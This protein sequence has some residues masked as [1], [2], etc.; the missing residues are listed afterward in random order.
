MPKQNPTWWQRLRTGDIFNLRELI[1][2]IADFRNAT[3]GPETDFDRFM[4]HKLPTFDVSP[5]ENLVKPHDI[6]ATHMLEKHARANWNG[7]DQRLQLFS[8]LYMMTLRNMGIP[9]YCHTALRT[10]EEQKRLY[11][12]G[13][14]QN[15]GPDAPHIRG[16]AVDIVHGKFHWDPTET[17][18][19][20]LGKIGRELNRLL[21]PGPP[22]IWGGDWNNNG[23]PVGEDPKERFWDPAHWQVA[24]WRNLPYRP[25]HWA[26]AHKSMTP[27]NLAAVRPTHT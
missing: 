25:T 17:E 15:P 24:G 3:N 26:A 18:W 23:V 13:R 22:I 1:D 16:Y 6:F 5:L 8:G 9:M 12:K 20:H 11:N 2:A 4:A 7:V 14:S 21:P 19:K 27:A 10:H